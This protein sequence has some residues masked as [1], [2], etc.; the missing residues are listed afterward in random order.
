[1]DFDYEINYCP[2]CGRK[3]V[4]EWNIKKNGTLATGV[5]S[6]L[7]NQKQKDYIRDLLELEFRL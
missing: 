6:R 4:E 3:L 5:V 7:R 1:M 2:K